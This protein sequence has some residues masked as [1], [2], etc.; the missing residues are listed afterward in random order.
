MALRK[1][2]M[3]NLIGLLEEDGL[4]HLAPDHPQIILLEM[5]C[6]LID[7]HGQRKG[8]ER[9]NKDRGC[10][11][12]TACYRYSRTSSQR[13]FWEQEKLTVVE[14]RSFMGR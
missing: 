10:C 13:E 5:V 2:K 4:L 1:G 3:I 11:S 12:R 6:S 8:R 7:T 9:V 14:R